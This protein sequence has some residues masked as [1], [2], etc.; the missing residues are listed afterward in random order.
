LRVASAPKCKSKLTSKSKGIRAEEIERKAR[1][2]RRRRERH[3]R[4]DEEDGKVRG[5]KGVKGMG[6]KCRGLLEA[7]MVG[8]WR[9][10]SQEGGCLLL[11]VACCLLWRCV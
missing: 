4:G 10:D 5:R 6:K 11:L 9:D 3:G 7:M 1:R 2:R 8:V